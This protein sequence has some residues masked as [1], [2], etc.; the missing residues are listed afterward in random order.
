MD[1]ILLEHKIHEC[2]SA[3]PVIHVSQLLS[4]IKYCDKP[5]DKMIVI[6]HMFNIVSPSLLK[7]KRF[8]N[9]ILDKMLEF[10]QDERI[11]NDKNLL[12]SIRIVEKKI[13][14]IYGEQLDAI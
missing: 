1:P 12:N 9:A 4:L 5:K 7:F 6:A 10:M 2:Y 13:V 3:E 14:G 11:L 8:V